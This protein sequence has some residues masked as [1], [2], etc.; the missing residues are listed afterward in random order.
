MELKKLNKLLIEKS[1]DWAYTQSILYDFLSNDLL[2]IIYDARNNIQELEEALGHCEGTHKP[3]FN[4][5]WVE[6]KALEEEIKNLYS[7][8]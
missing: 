8:D 1:E 6:L 7:N 3:A 2:P 5:T 4:Q